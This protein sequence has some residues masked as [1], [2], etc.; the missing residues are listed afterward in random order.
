MTSYTAV[1][2]ASYLLNR[3]LR[4]G[5]KDE[6]A[7]KDLT[8]SMGV[9]TGGVYGVLKVLKSLMNHSQFE[10]GSVIFC[11]DGWPRLSERRVALYPQYKNPDMVAPPSEED[12]KFRELYKETKVLVIDALKLFGIPSI[13]FP[14]REGDDLCSIV[15]EIV[16]GPVMLISDDKAYCQLVD[17]RRHVYRALKDQ[18][19][20]L[21]NFNEITG[22]KTPWRLLVYSSI[23]GGHDNVDGIK[24]VGGTTAERVANTMDRIGYAE[25]FRACDELMKTDTRNKSRY[26]KVKNNTDVILRN[27]MLIDLRQEKFTPEQMTEIRSTI[28]S[29][30]TFNELAVMQLF[31]TYEFKSY[32]SEFAQ[33][34]LPYRKL[35]EARLIS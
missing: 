15:S 13:Q 14:R 30:M 22:V 11:W 3:V 35:S 34:V 24:G 8:N 16:T 1:V 20:T 9:P 29:G 12:I 19:V 31:N 4:A 33:W 18:V 25:L 32:L 28:Q 2:D 5:G 23:C 21:E 26:E 27:L 6:M 10:I 7:Y 17:D